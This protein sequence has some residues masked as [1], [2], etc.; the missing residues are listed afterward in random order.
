M[1]EDP[2]YQLIKEQ[3]ARF[4][5]Q[6]TARITLLEQRLEHQAALNQDR[7]SALLETTKTLRDDLRDHESRLRSLAD[8]AATSRTWQS[9]LSGSG[10][11]TGLSALLKSFLGS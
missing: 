3:L 9:I 8:T 6:L 5:D 11:L 1:T 10:F 2:T 7:T 4:Q